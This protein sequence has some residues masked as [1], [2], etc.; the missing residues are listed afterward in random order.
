M[1]ARALLLLGL[2]GA[3]VDCGW[4]W[5]FGHG[6]VDDRIQRV[7]GLKLLCSLAVAAHY[8][9]TSERTASPAAGRVIG[10]CNRRPAL[11]VALLVV[12]AAAIAFA[13]T[14]QVA[15]AFSGGTSGQMALV[16]RRLPDRRQ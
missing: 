6:T 4:V 8:V 3:G 13:T 5:L 11:M 1:I 9:W 12:G 7:L 10:L 16:A 2:V 15:F 14:P